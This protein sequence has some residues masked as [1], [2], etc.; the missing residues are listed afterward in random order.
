MCSIRPGSACGIDRPIG[1]CAALQRARE[2]AS[3]G[4]SA[5]YCFRIT[6]EMA[7]WEDDTSSRTPSLHQ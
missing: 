7:F 2:R 3:G 4:M 1:R 5:C 6:F